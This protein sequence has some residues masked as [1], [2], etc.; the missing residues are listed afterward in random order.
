MNSAA[1]SVTEAAPASVPDNLMQHLLELLGERSNALHE[2]ATMQMDADRLVQME[3]WRVV[4]QH[5]DLT[6]L[7]A[8]LDTEIE[9][10]VR[11]K[12]DEWMADRKSIPTPFGTPKLTLTTSL[13]V[14]DEPRSL[15]LVIAELDPKCAKYV[16]LVPSLNLDALAEL[17]D[18]K[19]LSVGIRRVVEN[20]FSIAAVRVPLAKAVKAAVATKE[21]RK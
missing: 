16:R 17:T 7:V 11:H 5:A 13:E 12:E 1:K 6:E 10:L 15:E 2:L 3:A 21:V 20:R 14:N 8:A 9:A 19:L 4:K 18:E